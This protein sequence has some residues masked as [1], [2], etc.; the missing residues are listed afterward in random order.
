MADQTQT[1]TSHSVSTLDINQVAISHNSI[2]E[3]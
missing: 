2:D 1:L 3:E